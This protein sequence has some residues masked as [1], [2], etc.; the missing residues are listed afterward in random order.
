MKQIAATKFEGLLQVRHANFEA[1]GIKWRGIEQEKS[2]LADQIAC[3]EAREDGMSFDGL[4]NPTGVVIED[5]L[6]EFGETGEI[7]GMR[8]EES[9]STFTEGKMLR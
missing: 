8:T 4:Q 1:V 5:E 6:E 3:T 7:G 9:G 2:E